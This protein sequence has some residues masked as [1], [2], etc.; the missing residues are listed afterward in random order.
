MEYIFS[1]VGLFGL[2]I[3]TMIILTPFMSKTPNNEKSKKIIYDNQP[4]DTDTSLSDMVNYYKN[5]DFV[6]YEI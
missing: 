1:F 6:N 3:T 2:V 5:N 4:I